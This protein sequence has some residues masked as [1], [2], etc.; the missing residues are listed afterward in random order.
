[1]DKEIN[2]SKK[3]RDK[4]Q[5]AYDHTA[6]GVIDLVKKTIKKKKKKSSYPKRSGN[7]TRLNSRT[8]ATWSES[9]YR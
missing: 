9:K 3:K 5:K 7:K 1:M 6:I 4:A 2:K 8:T